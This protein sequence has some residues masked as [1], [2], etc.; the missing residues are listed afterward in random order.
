MV[1][2]TVPEPEI[3]ELDGFSSQFDLFGYREFGENLTNLFIN[4]DEPL[5]VLLDGPWG[6]GKSFFL[7]QW[8]GH[9]K[10]EDVPVIYHDAFSS[11]YQD[12]AF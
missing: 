1:R 6:S 9:L 3:G 5:V 7:K 12:D 4:I 11:D 2:L 8:I 10:S